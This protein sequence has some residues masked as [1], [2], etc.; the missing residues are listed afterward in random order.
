MLCAV[1][2]SM[3]YPICML[4]AVIYSMLYLFICCVLSSIRCYTLFVCCVLSSIRCYTFLYAVC[5]HLSDAIPF[6]MLCAVIYSMLY[7]FVCCVL[8]SIRCYT[9]LYA[10][11]M[12]YMLSFYDDMTYIR[13][14]IILYFYDLDL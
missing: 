9:L 12:C 1:I 10:I 2:Y 4:C 3:L 8:S 14:T 5:C 13:F 11:L 7:L 6:Y